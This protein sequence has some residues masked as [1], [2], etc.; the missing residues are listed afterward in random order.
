MTPYF[1]YSFSSSTTAQQLVPEPGDQ[2]SAMPEAAK[3]KWYHSVW[4]VLVML[5]FVLGPFGLPLVWKNPRFS[6][7]VKIALT[8]AMVV[9]MY[10]LVAFAVT[11]FKFTRNEFD[12]LQLTLPQ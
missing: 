6:G 2:M 10:Y 9:Y 1:L 11:I 8:V 5:F 3:A 7:W 4:F 12:Q